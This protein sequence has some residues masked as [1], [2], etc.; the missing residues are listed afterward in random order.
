VLVV[1]DKE[2]NVR[3]PDEAWWIALNN[4]DP[5]RDVRFTMGPIDVLDHSSRAFTYGSKMGIDATRKWKEEGFDREWP[6]LITMDAET[7][8]R[9][10]EMWGKLGITLA[11]RGKAGTRGRGNEGTNERRRP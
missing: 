1:V 5:E 4:I 3:D 10:D 6:R 2:V 11:E 9:V 8:R 7:K